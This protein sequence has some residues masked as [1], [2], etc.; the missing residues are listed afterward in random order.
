MSLPGC[1]SPYSSA[2]DTTIERYDLMSCQHS[3]RPSHLQLGSIIPEQLSSPYDPYPSKPF[4]ETPIFAQSLAVVRW[5][6]ELEPV[7]FSSKGRD[8]SKRTIGFLII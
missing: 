2:I 7:S 8:Y 6:G 3:L 5:E 4:P 1:P